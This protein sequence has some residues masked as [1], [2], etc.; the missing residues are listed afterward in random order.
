[1]QPQLEQGSVRVERAA[2]QLRAEKHDPV[3]AE[4]LLQR[5]DK[6]RT[7]HQKAG[8]ILPWVAKFLG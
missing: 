7:W 2:R 3:D 8:G 5:L 6:L 1:M 4:K